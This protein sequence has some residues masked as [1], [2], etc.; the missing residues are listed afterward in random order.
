[1]N[2]TFTM[3]VAPPDVFVRP[4]GELDLFSARQL[5]RNV[6][7]AVDEGCRQ[8]LLD[9]ADVTFVDAGALGVLARLRTQMAE[10]G[11]SLRVVDWSPRFL[12]VCQLAGLDRAFG[13][14]EP[15]P[16]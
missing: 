8:V 3:D 2:F 11:G 12:Q 5:A 9:L 15:I 10:L 16:A 1:M 14:A 6:Q 13:L 4:Q 7:D